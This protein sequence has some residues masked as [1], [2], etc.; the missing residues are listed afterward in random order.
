MANW[1]DILYATTDNAPHEF[2][3]YWSYDFTE[4][5][6]LADDRGRTP[7]AMSWSTARMASTRTLLHAHT[8]ASPVARGSRTA[9]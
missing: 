2:I 1:Q 4:L 3:L 6:R 9:A 8:V 5:M 7:V